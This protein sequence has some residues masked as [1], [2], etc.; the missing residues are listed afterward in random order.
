MVGA[1]A[2]GAYV[3]AY[4][5]RAGED[6]T[7]IDVWPDQVPGRPG[8]GGYQFAVGMDIFSR[9]IYG[10]RVAVQ[11]GIVVAVLSTVG[12]VLIG[13]FIGLSESTRGIVGLI[14]RMLNQ[15][16]SYLL[17]IPDIILGIV[18]VGIMG[19][20]D[21][22]LTVAITLCLIQAPVKLTRVEVL[23]VRRRPGQPVGV[24]V[25]GLVVGVDQRVQSTGG[26]PHAPPST[27]KNPN[28]P[29]LFPAI[30]FAGGVL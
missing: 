6:V 27:N 14:G 9:T 20:S 8:F 5:A 10:A 13:T 15:I 23:R 17:A 19:S 25:E 26:R 3:G 2:M 30:R 7:L 11:F 22:A 12:G 24:A 28:P 4:M 16:S 18:V 1:G 21:F 29:R